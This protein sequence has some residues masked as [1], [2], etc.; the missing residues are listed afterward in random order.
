MGEW[1]MTGS[2]I[3]PFIENK[4]DKRKVDFRTL[5]KINL[6]FI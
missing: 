2:V 4:G 3:Q 1:R 6:E 5:G